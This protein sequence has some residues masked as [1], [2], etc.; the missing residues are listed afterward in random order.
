MEHEALATLGLSP[1]EQK[2]LIALLTRGLAGKT[3]LA[4][5]A[6]VS[7]SKIYEIAERLVDKGLAFKQGDVGSVEYGALPVENLR[8][9]IHKRKEDLRRQEKALE[10][11][12]QELRRLAAQEEERVCLLRGEATVRLVAEQLASD[13]L[14]VIGDALSDV[15]A[16]QM[17]SRHLRSERIDE[18]KGHVKRLK[19]SQCILITKTD[20]LLADKELI[21][22]THIHQPLIAKSMKLLFETLWSTC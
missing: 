8:L 11:S 13:E 12:I 10:T 14:C 6:G 18:V 3:K 22:A 16:R 4:A 7:S 17:G 20:V 5:N 2:V 19:T 21:V 1:G 15:V 9:I